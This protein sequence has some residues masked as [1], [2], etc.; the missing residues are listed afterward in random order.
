M[1]GHPRD[2]MAVNTNAY[3]AQK[4]AEKIAENKTDGGRTWEEVTAKE[5]CGWIGIVIYIG[6]HCSPA[7]IYMGMH[8]SPAIFEVGWKSQTYP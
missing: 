4:I 6:M 3:A 5:L 1:S 8:C 2:T 7:I